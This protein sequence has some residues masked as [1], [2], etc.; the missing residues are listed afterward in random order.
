MQEIEQFTNQEMQ[1]LFEQLNQA[2]AV[3][4]EHFYSQ[5]QLKCLIHI[6]TILFQRREFQKAKEVIHDALEISTNHLER[7]QA[8]EILEKVMTEIE[9]RCNNLIVFLNSNPLVDRQKGVP[10][11]SNESQRFSENVEIMSYIQALNSAKKQINMKFEVLT[12]EQLIHT[13]NHGCRILV[14]NQNVPSTTNLCIETGNGDYEEVICT[15]LVK[16]LKS[17]CVNLNIDTVFINI[18]GAFSTA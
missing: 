6:A 8:T 2:C 15:D 7:K 4:E 13:A 10:V 16:V 5:L 17:R 1:N 18:P 11:C 14:L 12:K 9:M 3:F